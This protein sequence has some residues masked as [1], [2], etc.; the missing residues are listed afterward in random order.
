M[1]THGQQAKVFERLE[2]LL[3]HVLSI[4]YSVFHFRLIFATSVA[5]L[6]AAQRFRPDTLRGL[7]KWA[8]AYITK[9]SAQAVPKPAT[10]A[11]SDD[12]TPTTMQ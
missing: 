3:V 11:T 8:L 1:R 12:L 10:V 9:D 6:V 7:S 4:A 2:C 5:S